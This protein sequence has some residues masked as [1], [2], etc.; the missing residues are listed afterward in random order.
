MLMHDLLSRLCRRT[1]SCIDTATIIGIEHIRVAL[2]VP[3]EPD[4]VHLMALDAR[5]FITFI[6]YFLSVDKLK[7]VVYLF[8]IGAFVYFCASICYLA[9]FPIVCL[10]LCTTATEVVL[11]PVITVNGIS[12]VSL[13]FYHHKMLL[14]RKRSSRVDGWPLCCPSDQVLLYTESGRRLW[15]QNN[16]VIL[17]YLTGPKLLIHIRG[18]R[19]WLRA[20]SS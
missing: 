10:F 2:G 11:W 16:S 7:L 6:K 18:S 14:L 3:I 19:G 17:T 9:T 20:Q 13:R 4:V 8:L 12:L 1:R 5:F 15:V